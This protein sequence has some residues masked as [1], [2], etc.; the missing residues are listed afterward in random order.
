MAISS[1]TREPEFPVDRLFLDRWS[2]RAFAPD[3][4]PHATLM[5]LFEAARWAPSCFN[6]QPWYFVYASE[7]SGLAKMRSILVEKNRIWADRAPVLAL[8]CSQKQ[9][10]HNNQP[11]R[12][13]PF[14]AGAAWMS[15]ALQASM[16]GLCAHAMGGFDL[17]AAYTTLGLPREKFDIHAAVAIGRRGDPKLLPED[18]AAREAPSGRKPLAEIIRV[19]S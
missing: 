11:N 7:A 4:I 1:I 16:L 14:D 3:P 13:A 9:F 12:W 6:D 15:L 17:E 8:V 2:P 5:T 10:K 18:I 19:I